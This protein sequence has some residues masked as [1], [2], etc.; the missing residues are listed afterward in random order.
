MGS[1]RCSELKIIHYNEL[2]VNIY[3]KD[4]MEKPCEI[5]LVNACCS[6]PCIDF[7]KYVYVKGQYVNAGV[8]VAK[9]I[10]GMTYDEAIKHILKVETVY[11]NLKRVSQ[12][13][14]P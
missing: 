9:H 10:K 11:F 5:C 6:I 3:R 7:A 13:E 2:L 8:N 1:K 12:Q 14:L 4:D